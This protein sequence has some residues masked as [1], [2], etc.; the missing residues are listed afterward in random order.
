MHRGTRVIGLSCRV[1]AHVE[2]VLVGFPA[3]LDDVVAQIRNGPDVGDKRFVVRA[4]THDLASQQPR[5]SPPRSRY[6]QMRRA[7]HSS[8]GRVHQD[9]GRSVVTDQPVI[10][11]SA[12]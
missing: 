1:P 3:T 9:S 11:T 5:A 7:T 6:L 4:G 8:A 10:S 2:L 12:S